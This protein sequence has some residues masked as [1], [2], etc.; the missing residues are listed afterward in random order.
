MAEGFAEV[1]EGVFQQGFCQPVSNY[2][3]SRFILKVYLTVYNYFAYE[4]ILNSDIFR[5]RIASK[6]FSEREYFLVIVIYNYNRRADYSNRRIIKSS[7]V[8]NLFS[9]TIFN[10]DIIVTYNIRLYILLLSIRQVVE[11]PLQ[12]DYFLNYLS[13][14][15]ILYFAKRQSYYQ[16]AFRGL[17]NNVITDI[18]DV[19]RNRPLSISITALV[20][21]YILRKQF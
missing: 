3:F 8:F 11:K 12:L 4:V 15:Y 6:V 10:K 5:F 19:A 1:E 2:L 18:K 20:G 21:I 16:L 14:T 13:L 7:I 17:V 9:Q